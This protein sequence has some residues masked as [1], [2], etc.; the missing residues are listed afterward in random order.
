MRRRVK[1]T[2]ITVAALLLVAVVGTFIWYRTGGLDRLVESSMR[3]ALAEMN[4]RLGVTK[5]AVDLRP[6]Q[7]VLEGLQLYPGED[8]EPFVSVERVTVKFDITSL[9]QQTVEVRPSVVPS[10]PDAKRRRKETFL[11]VVPH[12][13]ARHVGQIGQ[14]LNRKARLLGHSGINIYS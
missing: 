4:I 7:V 14:I 11:H 8:Q 12:R 9:W 3:E 5:T 10:P 13:S 1:I 2:L 6:G